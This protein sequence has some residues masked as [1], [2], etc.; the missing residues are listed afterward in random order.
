MKT[1]IILQ[2]LLTIILAE[3]VFSARPFV[4]IDSL[5]GNAEIQ[6]NGRYDWQTASK[7]EN[8]YTN[9]IIRVLN[10]GM[11]ILKWSDGSILY[12]S[13]N[14]QILINILQKN[15]Q[16]K[17]LCHST[18]FSGRIYHL[19]KKYT[20][21]EISSNMRVYTPGSLISL[22][23]R[24]SFE[25]SVDP[26]DGTTT[27]KVTNGIVELKNIK[28]GAT[29]FLSASRKAVIREKTRSLTP[30][31]LLDSDLD[32]LKRWVP[33][34]L[35]DGEIAKQ[36]TKSKRDH[37]FIS[38]NVQDTC[39]FFPF[40]N[41]SSYSGNWEIGSG[42]TGFL[43]ER[44]K[45]AADWMAILVLDSAVKDPVLTA[46]HHNA[47]YAITG[48]VETF[49]IQQ[50]AEI[51]TNADNYKETSSGKVKFAVRIFDVAEKEL[52]SEEV[53]TGEVTK[54]LNEKNK[55]KTVDSLRF[56]LADEA[57]VNSIIGSATLQAV[58][59]ASEKL[60]RKF[61]FKQE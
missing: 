58:D 39:I 38:R 7:N 1:S 31:A 34:A 27:V 52:L 3:P 59:G 43:A 17:Q 33:S 5:S 46:A 6:R 41:T 10:D 21:P 24:T 35:I 32:S 55:W 57:F 2:F 28:T 4:L 25:V 22:N 40:S 48:S 9:D 53:F 12:V 15:P 8:L 16:D 56:D 18:I 45:R 11:A 42:I 36:L 23:G 61:L 54:E 13:Q 29:L 14:T 51:T 20:P 47:K 44:M 30:R 19:S 60:T 26:L 49:D 50:R 37:L